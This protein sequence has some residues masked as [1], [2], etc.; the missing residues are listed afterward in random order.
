MKDIKSFL[1][2]WATETQIKEQSGYSRATI[3]IALAYLL[4]KGVL[5]IKKFGNAR[6]YKVK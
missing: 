2:E 6:V 4:G 3:D 1:K 5:K